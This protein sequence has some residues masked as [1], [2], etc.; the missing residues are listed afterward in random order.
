M[1]KLCIHHAPKGASPMFILFE[2]LITSIEVRK[3]KTLQCY[4][5]ISFPFS[6]KLNFLSYVT[7]EIHVQYVCKFRNIEENSEIS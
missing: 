5:K 3:N 2:F 4:V 7:F 6:E 1:A